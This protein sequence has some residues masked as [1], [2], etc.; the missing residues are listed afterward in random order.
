MKRALEEDGAEKSD[1]QDPPD[2]GTA[3]GIKLNKEEVQEETFGKRTLTYRTVMRALITLPNRSHGKQ[4]SSEA[5]LL[6]R[7]LARTTDGKYRLAMHVPTFFN[8]L[9]QTIFSPDPPGFFKGKPHFLVL[10]H[11]VF[12]QEDPTFDTVY[13]VHAQRCDASSLVNELTCRPSEY[14]YVMRANRNL[15]KIRIHSYRQMHAATDYERFNDWVWKFSSQYFSEYNLNRLLPLPPIPAQDTPK[16]DRWKWCQTAGFSIYVP[17]DFSVSYALSRITNNGCGKLWHHYMK[18]W[19]LNLFT[20]QSSDDNSNCRFAFNT[21]VAPFLD[22]QYPTWVSRKCA[23]LHTRI[24]AG[25][26]RR[27]AAEVVVREPCV[28]H[29]IVGTWASTFNMQFVRSS[30]TVVTSS[31][32]FWRAVFSPDSVFEDPQS[33]W[34]ELA[35]Q[36]KLRISGVLTGP[37]GVARVGAMDD[38]FS[39]TSRIQQYVLIA[40]DPTHNVERYGPAPN[41]IIACVHTKSSAPGAFILAEEQD[42]PPANLRDDLAYEYVTRTETE[43]F[44]P[45]PLSFSNT[46]T[47]RLDGVILDGTCAWTDAELQH[48]LSLGKRVRFACTPDTKSMADELVV[49]ANAMCTVLESI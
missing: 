31:E 13:W 2:P 25:K 7:F 17:E 35:Q 46:F 6:I 36:K 43:D 22:N 21:F 9:Q 45:L 11:P 8:H 39:S 44:L 29:T 27:D 49:R 4:H 30:T 38:D 40:P 16:L 26:Q 23:T 1:S 12:E 15:I 28:T 32:G 3:T 18:N 47:H 34:F 10:N 24:Q 20:T 33:P 14:G 41:R 19:L 48:G 5:V 37:T 42:S